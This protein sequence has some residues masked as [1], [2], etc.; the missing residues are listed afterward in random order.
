[1]ITKCMLISLP[2]VRS[3]LESTYKLEVNI[4]GF[5]YNLN[6]K[7]ALSHSNTN[8]A[9]SYLASKNR[10]RQDESKVA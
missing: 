1:M 9:Q 8:Q 5:V 2:A 7:K 10:E 4:H 3:T 6:F